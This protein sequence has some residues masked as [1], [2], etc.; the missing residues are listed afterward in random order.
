MHI[1][2]VL[3]YRQMRDIMAAADKSV[4]EYRESVDRT[5]Q[6]MNRL[7]LPADVQN[8]VRMWFSYSWSTQ[9]S[10]GNIKNNSGAFQP[11]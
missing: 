5:V 1:K 2:E 10:L 7:H 6:F 8:R 9:K 3:F 11:L 4:N